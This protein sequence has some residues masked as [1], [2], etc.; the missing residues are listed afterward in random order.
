MFYLVDV[1]FQIIRH[2]THFQVILFLASL[3]NLSGSGFLIMFEFLCVD[4][5]RKAVP[6]H[7]VH[8]SLLAICT[9]G[10]LTHRLGYDL[11][12]SSIVICNMLFCDA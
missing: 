10:R 9:I 2:K 6:P 11:P 4:L 5:P 12:I 7:V 1:H 8:I 3:F